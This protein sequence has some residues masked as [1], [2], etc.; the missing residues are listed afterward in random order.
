MEAIKSDNVVDIQYVSPSGLCTFSRCPARFFFKHLLRLKSRDKVSIALDY[1]KCIHACMPDAYEHPEIAI[2]TFSKMWDTMGHG[3]VDDKRNTFRALATF[4]EFAK[5]HSST[6]SPYIPLDPPSGVIESKER[7]TD[8]EAP[9]L[10]DIG[11]SFPL[12]G[13]IDRFV[14]LREDKTVWPLDY[15]TSSEISP[16]IFSNFTSSVQTLAYTLAG[17]YLWGEEL[18]GIII[19]LLRTSKTN[20]ECAMHLLYVKPLWLETFVSW[21]NKII[22][23]IDIYNQLNK[24]SKC[25]TGCAPYGM[26]GS[27]GY[28]CEYEMLCDLKD[29]REGRKFYDQEEWNP[30]K[31]DKDESK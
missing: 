18:P 31:G 12:Y 11:A 20:A 24:W 16:R 1:G 25:P 19:E 4:S 21:A 5:C 15:K 27:P 10:I 23:K 29:W 3:E 28:C 2:K 17:S 7:Y 6:I 26:F 22:N 14:R 30:L 9:F 8:Y 13:K